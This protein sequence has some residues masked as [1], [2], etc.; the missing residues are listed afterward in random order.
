MLP[1]P[2][3]AAVPR[4]ETP[5][6]LAR[7]DRATIEAV[8]RSDRRLLV[9]GGMG[10]NSSDGLAGKVARHRG[11]RLVGVGTISAVL[12]TEEQLRAEI[13]RARAEAPGG[14][15]GVNLMAAIDRRDFQALAQVAIAE[16]VSFVVQGAGISRRRLLPRPF[17]VLNAG[18]SRRTRRRYRRHAVRTRAIGSGACTS[19]S[20]G[21]AGEG[22]LRDLS[23]ER[24]VE[25]PG[26]RDRPLLYGGG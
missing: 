15:V 2:E 19:P 1:S 5:A 13:R 26:R 18:K 9:Q 21:R 7:L 20:G 14:F 23:C 8:L 11:A 25:P 16:R 17:L 6:P 4:P 10:I 24:R 22:R 3:A 12:K